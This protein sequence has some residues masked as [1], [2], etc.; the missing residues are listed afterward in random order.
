M[1]GEGEVTEKTIKVVLL[2]NEGN[3]AASSAEVIMEPVG[4]TEEE[5]KLNNPLPSPYIIYSSYASP[6]F[7]MHAS[8]PFSE[9]A[10]YNVSG[11]EEV[12]EEARKVIM[13]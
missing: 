8:N 6:T 4:I 13:S 1:S 3:T 12:T 2:E 5:V 9:D 10:K 7:F 11:K